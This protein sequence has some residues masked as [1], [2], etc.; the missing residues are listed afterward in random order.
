MNWATAF[1]IQEFNCFRFSSTS[2]RNNNEQEQWLRTPAEQSE[3]GGENN[4]ES[5]LH[6]PKLSFFRLL[7]WAELEA[8]AKV[9]SAWL[10]KVVNK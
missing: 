1:C 3:A 4:F 7:R 6:T 10:E 9:N 8:L 2:E 5:A